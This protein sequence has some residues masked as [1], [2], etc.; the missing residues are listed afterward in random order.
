MIDHH[1]ALIYTMVMVSAV[2]Q[3]MNDEELQ[4]IGDMIKHLPIFND[5]DQNRLTETA[6][7]CAA[8]LEKEDGLDQILDLILASLPEKLRETAY[9]LACDV[10]AADS[11]VSQEELRLLEMIRHHLDIDRLSAAAIERG[12]RAHYILL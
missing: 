4:T 9:A 7:A 11:H 10:A 1:D 12:A 6:N 3:D 2:D 5:Y 8:L